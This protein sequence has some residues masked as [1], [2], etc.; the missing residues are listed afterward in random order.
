MLISQEKVDE[1]LT[2]FEP[3]YHDLLKYQIL[4]LSNAI[5]E[6]IL[7]YQH[8]EDFKRALNIMLNDIVNG[9]YL[10]IGLK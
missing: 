7:K 10:G 1:I 3:Q 9:K 2:H 5:E 4:V 8:S 6:N